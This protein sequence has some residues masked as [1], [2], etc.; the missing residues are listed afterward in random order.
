MQARGHVT[1]ERMKKPRTPE[2]AET[3]AH[4]SP[5]ESF[6]PATRS[7]FE[8]SFEAPTRV[9][10]MAWPTIA[11]GQHYLVLAPTG[12]GKTLAAFLVAI[13]RLMF[14]GSSSDSPG[15]TTPAPMKR[16]RER[17][18]PCRVLYVSPL[19]ALAVD[20]E[21]NLRARGCEVVTFGALSAG[22]DDAWPRA[23]RRVG[24][25]VAGSNC[26]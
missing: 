25:A 22:D 16:E 19:R 15:T 5:L 8:A 10:L 9:Q 6:H 1:H 18:R 17:R 11:T 3:R 13:N 23:G 24:E 12:S 26:I 21:R 7:W 4:A 14:G 20:V 2:P